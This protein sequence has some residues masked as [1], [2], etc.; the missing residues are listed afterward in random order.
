MD[1]RL[2][3]SLL[4][5]RPR[6]RGRLRHAAC[7]LSDDRLA[8]ASRLSR[9]GKREC[10]RARRLHRRRPS[11]P[12]LPGARGSLSLSRSRCRRESASSARLF[13]RTCSKARAFSPPRRVAVVIS[14]AMSGV[15]PRTPISCAKAKFI[16]TLPRSLAALVNERLQNRMTTARAPDRARAGDHDRG[17]DHDASCGSVMEWISLFWGSRIKPLRRQWFGAYPAC[18][19]ASGASCHSSGTTLPFSIVSARRPCFSSSA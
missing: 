12:R 1:R 8:R 3:K 6:K 9:R 4:T 7:L 14:A 11:G 15:L 18:S 10:R 13:P 2:L 19:P 5:R 17:L 16:L